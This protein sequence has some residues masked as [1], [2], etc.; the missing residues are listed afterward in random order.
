E[1]SKLRNWGAIGIVGVDFDSPWHHWGWKSK[2]PCLATTLDECCIIINKKNNIWFDEKN[3][4]NWHAYGVDF[5]LQA[6][7]KGLDVYIMNGPGFHDDTEKTYSL[8][9]DFLV[10]LEHYKKVLRKKWGDK[11]PQ[12]HT[13]TG[14]F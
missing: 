6:R 7:D 11:F 10:N 12:L 3:C 13:T 4:N 5:C 1:E 2:A 8:P 14:A 9:K